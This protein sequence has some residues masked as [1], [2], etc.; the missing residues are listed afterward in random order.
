MSRDDGFEIADVS[1]ALLDD[2]K[3]RDLWRQL[4]DECRMTHAITLY[5]ATILASWRDGCRVPVAD[6]VPVWLAPDGEL[7]AALVRARLLDRHG[8]LPPRSWNGWFGPAY[9]RRE[10]RRAAGRIGGMA[11]GSARER[12]LKQPLTDAEPVR[13]DRTDRTDRKGAASKN[14]ATELLRAALLA[15]DEGRMP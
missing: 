5:V 6:A 4:G 10:A 11:S 12:L 7:V 14:D 3:V 8:K 2:P 15:Q 9:A 1:T 13:T